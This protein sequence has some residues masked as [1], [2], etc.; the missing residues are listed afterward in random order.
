VRRDGENRAVGPC[1][2][3]IASPRSAAVC[4]HRRR[5]GSPG[6]L[7]AW[8][9][10]PRPGA[11]RS[12][13]RGD[14]R[15]RAGCRLERC[16]RS[17]A[18]EGARWAWA[19]ADPRRPRR[20]PD[21]RG[22]ASGRAG[23]VRRRVRRP[24]RRGAAYGRREGRYGAARSDRRL[25]NVRRAGRRNGPATPGRRCRSRAEPP[26]VGGAG[27]APGRPV[28]R[29]AAASGAESGPIAAERRPEARHPRPS[30][31]R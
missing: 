19:E 14:G 15:R 16:S 28:G 31:P 18:T 26:G 30:A 1:W 6:V 21:L 10:P 2:K 12:L 13:A 5:A 4:R 17:A 29:D 3:A 23:R 20:R 11:G 7:G 8:I 25:V 22:G 24:G 9:R 27:K